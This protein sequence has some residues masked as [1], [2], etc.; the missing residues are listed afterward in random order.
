MQFDGVTQRVPGGE[1]ALAK[2]KTLD[3]VLLVWLCMVQFMIYLDRG[4]VAGVLDVMQELYKIDNTHAGLLGSLFV[5]GYMLSCPIFGYLGHYVHRM[6]LI[7]VGLSI[8]IFANFL[9]GYGPDFK[10]MIIS[11]ILTGVG[12][13]AFCTLSVPLTNDLAPED[14]KARWVSTV[15]LFIVVGNAI[16]FIYGEKVVELTGNLALAFRIEAYMMVPLVLFTLIPIVRFRVTSV[17]IAQR[18]TANST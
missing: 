15:T 6:T 18:V 8:W 10:T 14:H 17:D 9:A 11:R 12:E 3:Y 4:T 5:G 13:A 7:F 16:G 1:D 2:G